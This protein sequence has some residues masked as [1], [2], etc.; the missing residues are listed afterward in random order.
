MIVGE[1]THIGSIGQH[2]THLTPIAPVVEVYDPQTE[3]Y[4]KRLYWYKHPKF[5]RRYAGEPGLLGAIYGSK[6]APVKVPK[7]L[8]G[9]YDYIRDRVGDY[10]KI[11]Q[12][13]LM[14]N[15]RHVD[16]VVV[17][18][19]NGVLHTFYFDVSGPLDYMASQMK[20]AWERM[21]R[22]NPNLR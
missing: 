12:A 17:R 19:S 15:G 21:K 6:E 16:E 7:Y 13:L 1:A 22:E 8:W 5:I 4:L 3:A 18:G 10:E 20:T 14:V 2:I 11:R 9:E